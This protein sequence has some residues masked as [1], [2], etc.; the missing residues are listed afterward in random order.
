MNG[1]R[2][3]IECIFAV[4]VSLLCLSL[5]PAVHARTTCAYTGAPTNL[6]TVTA[7]GFVFA[8]IMRDGEEIVVAES[9]RRRE[10]CTGGVP[11]V[12]NTDTI[13]VLI[14]RGDPI[15]E[16]ELGGGPFAPGAT[17]EVEGAPEIEVE[18][19]GRVFMGPVVGT[20]GADEFH[21]G[22]GGTH[23][24]MNLNPRSAGDR[25][26]DVL[27]T[28][29]AAVLVAVGGGG[30]DTIIPAAGAIVPEGAV[31]Y[32][33][34]GDDLLLAPLNGGSILDA[35]RGN[36]VVTGSTKRDL[37]YGAAGNDRVVGAGGRDQIIGGLGRDLLSGG[38]GRDHINSRDST[39]DRVRCGPGRDFV[40][41][42]RRDR[43]H[44]CELTRRR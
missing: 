28:G 40:R 9:F 39:R 17:P 42:D 1:K 5:A 24:A 34:R 14:R 20:P 27:A 6:L 2:V 18:F 12:F 3:P 8:G 4:G 25:D 10:R 19:R 22:P 31:S 41:A 44:G 21:W 32:G 13:R 36:D 38:R 35:G 16:L 30:N 15:V 23:A 37:L 7:S 33:G 26:V 43:L 11:T 29:R